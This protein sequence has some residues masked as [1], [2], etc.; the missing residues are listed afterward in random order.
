MRFKHSL[1][2]LVA[3]AVIAMYAYEQLGAPFKEGEIVPDF[4]LKDLSGDIVSL[5]RYKG[6]PVV[7]HF[8]ATWCGICKEE[9]GELNSFAGDYPEIVVLVVSEDDN[10]I[11]IADFFTGATPHYQILVD[12]KGT[13][14][15][16]Y[17]SYKIPETFFISANGEFIHK[18]S[19][20]VSWND[21]KIREKIANFFNLPLVNN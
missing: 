15:D 3:L 18:T 19:G 17:K 2:F 8:W 1:L 7:I 20:A 12:D 11:S 6:R 4:S 9:M 21:T 16:A 14:A 5:S 13:A 10:A